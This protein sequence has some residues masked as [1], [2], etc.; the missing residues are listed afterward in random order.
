MATQTKTQDSKLSG[1]LTAL[2]NPRIALTS[3][4]GL[5]LGA[6]FIPG[7]GWLAFVAAIAGSYEA[8][9]ASADSLKEKKIDV[10]LLMVFAAIGAV[11]VGR[12]SDAAALLFLFSLSITLESIAMSR[13]KS[14]IESLVR[15]RPSSATL[16]SGDTETTVEV[17]KLQI[18]DTIR[19]H[20]YESVPTD[21]V[22]VVGRTKVDASAMTG[23]SLPVECGEGDLI[24]GGTQNLEG[25]VTARVTATVGDSALDRIVS[26]VKDAQ[27]NKASGQRISDWFGQTYTFFV[28]G[29]F[30]VSFVV[31]MLLKETVPEA[32]YLSLTLLVGMSP[33]ALVISTPATTLSALAWCARNGILVRGG[34]F[35][36]LAGK[37]NAIAL[38]KTGTL[39][40]GKPHLDL[41]AFSEFDSP[42]EIHEFSFIQQP[43]NGLSVPSQPIKEAIAQIAAIER[44]SNHPIA[45]AIVST[46]DE[47][48][49]DIPEITDHKVLSGLGV[50]A[51]TSAGKVLIGRERLLAAENISI[52]DALQAALTQAQARGFTVSV[53][54]T[55][56]GICMLAFSDSVRS[57]APSFVQHLKDLGLKHITILTGDRL[58]TAKTVADQV[59]ITEVYAGLMPGEKTER[60][61]ELSQQCEV[62]MVGDGVN[63]A[64]S[65]AS[66]SVGVAMG[67]LGSDVAMNAADVV[68]MHDRLDRIPDLIRLGRMT[69]A[70]IRMNLGFAGLMIIAL[71]FSSLVIRLPLPIAVLGHEG[72]TVLVILNGLRM[73]RGPREV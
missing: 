65:L 40:W 45:T 21:A 23:E 35:I 44:F 31:R 56:N 64:P 46:A 3:V 2:R 57:N 26:L 41:V 51:Y 71:T 60:I 50:G 15:L 8:V 34:E 13:T 5:T 72:S 36:E 66:A 7:L 19:I 18:G 33:C 11:I 32:F 4:C 39:T 48:Q 59:G 22:I 52:P 55:P 12:V 1:F 53:G 24:V 9:K 63:D 14:A 67:R 68:L 43:E 69:V 30:G 6:S 47:L 10:N 25:T 54:A 42:N 17:E 58:E 38:D 29:S 73:L 28:L 49:I 37:V 61:K 62:M 27:E 70:T 20:A 16:L